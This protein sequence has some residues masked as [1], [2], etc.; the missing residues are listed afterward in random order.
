[1]SVRVAHRKPYASTREKTGIRLE[2][3]TFGAI[4]IDDVT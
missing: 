2:R 4:R 1:M 3:F